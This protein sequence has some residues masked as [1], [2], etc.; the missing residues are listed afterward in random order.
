MSSGCITISVILGGHDCGQGYT[1]DDLAM[2][3]IFF[4]MAAKTAR[5]GRQG[6]VFCSEPGADAQGKLLAEVSIDNPNCDGS[7]ET[8]PGLGRVDPNGRSFRFT[9]DCGCAAALLGG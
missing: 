9:M 3:G 5:A 4:S 6:R 8:V 7:G 2:L 1:A